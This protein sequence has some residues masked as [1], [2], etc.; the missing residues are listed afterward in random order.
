LAIKFQ[1]ACSLKAFIQKS[2]LYDY[3]EA[4][5]NGVKGKRLIDS[6]VIILELVSS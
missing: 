6:I 2:N 4:E 1:S 3:W 5:I